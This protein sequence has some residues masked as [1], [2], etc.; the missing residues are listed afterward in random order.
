[1]SDGLI[2]NLLRNYFDYMFTISET[3]TSPPNTFYTYRRKLFATEEMN[4]FIYDFYEYFCMRNN[5]THIYREDYSALSPVY[6]AHNGKLFDISYFFK[7]DTI[8]SVFVDELDKQNLRSGLKCLTIVI[9]DII[10][11]RNA[12]ESIEGI[13]I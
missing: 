11:R 9:Y 7:C 8:D 6:G 13:N 1:M 2:A 3:M 10:C 12:E 5:I 4:R